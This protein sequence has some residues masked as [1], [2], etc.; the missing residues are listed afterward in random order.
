VFTDLGVFMDTATQSV[1]GSK[2]APSLRHPVWMLVGLIIGLAAAVGGMA[3]TEWLV[4]GAAGSNSLLFPMM[5]AVMGAALFRRGVP[6]VP[7]WWALVGFPLLLATMVFL[8]SLSR[9][10]M[11]PGGGSPFVILLAAI[12]LTSV[13]YSKSRR[14][15][16]TTEDLRRGLVLMIVI[17]T[18]LVATCIAISVAASVAP[19]PTVQSALPASAAAAFG[20]WCGMAIV[21]LAW[22]VTDRFSLTSVR[23]A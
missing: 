5:T 15:A 21:A 18:A 23:Q 8:G 19:W 20:V 22:V 13:A 16:P 3:I 2:T 1:D 4:P 14:P 9:A 12:V 17:L 7:K 11:T 10:S 6:N